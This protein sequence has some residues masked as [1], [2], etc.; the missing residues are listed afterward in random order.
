MPIPVAA[1]FKARLDFDSVNTGVVGLNA[2]RDRYV[3][4]HF[5]LLRR[6]F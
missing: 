6:A 4:P 2:D 5:H 1:L 3:C